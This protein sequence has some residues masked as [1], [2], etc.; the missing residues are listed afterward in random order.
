[1]GLADLSMD[2]WQKMM[3]LQ[4]KIAEV[5]ARANRERLE[6]GLAIFALAR[7]QRELLNN[8][9]E[10]TRKMLVDQILVPFIQGEAVDEQL[11]VKLH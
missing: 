8:Y 9:P 5:L 7:L 4:K 1:M 10:N 11:L 3:A 6:A 2:D